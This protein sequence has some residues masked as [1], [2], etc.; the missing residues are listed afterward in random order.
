MCTM[1]KTNLRS[2]FLKPKPW[3]A[4]LATLA[5]S[6]MIVPTGALAQAT[7][8]SEQLTA[9]VEQ[10]ILDRTSHLNAQVQVY[11]EPVANLR[12]D[13]ED[14]EVYLPSGRK[15]SS[16]TTVAVRCL[17]TSGA[18]AYVRADVQAHGVY[19]VAAQTIAANQA[20]SDDLLDEAE[21][22]LL[23]LPNGVIADAS[24]LVGRIATQ[25]L[26]PGRPIRA[27]ATRGPGSV[28]RGQSVRIEVRV[29]GMTVTN[30]G[31]A[32]SNAEIGMPVQVR[33][34]QGKTIQAVVV[35]S[36]VVAFNP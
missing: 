10:F 27:S 33:T 3:A 32:V 16:K 36:G 18:P 30:Q 12:L 2:S 11:V 9:Q 25:R 35:D 20:I 1:R 31:E 13:C 14:M 28:V 29:P 26:L 21:G 22:D 7:D 19:P 23:K 8:L 24:T 34:A 6:L 4:A 15:I 17:G 5:I